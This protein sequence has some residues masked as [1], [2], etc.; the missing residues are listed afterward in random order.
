MGLVEVVSDLDRAIAAVEQDSG[1]MPML[2]ATTA[3]TRAGASTYGEVGERLRA[4]DAP[5]LLLLGTGYGLTDEVFARCDAHLEPIQ[6]TGDYNHLSVRA[7][8]A[9]MLDRLRR[10]SDE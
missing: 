7:A 10:A 3:R 9:I 8:A 5:V 1:R 4:G 6:G 2:V